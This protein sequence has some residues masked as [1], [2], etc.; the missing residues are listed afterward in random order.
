MATKIQEQEQREKLL[1]I[2]QTLRENIIPKL[3]DV[4]LTV[5]IIAEKEYITRSEVKEEYATK[6]D[7][8]FIKRVVYGVIMAI[9]LGFIGLGFAI[10]QNRLVQ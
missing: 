9:L 10:I 3:N 4:K 1:S 2:E 8:T 7:V 5:N 6:E